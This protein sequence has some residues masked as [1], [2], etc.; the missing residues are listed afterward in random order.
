MA[1]IRDD[2]D[3]VILR[4]VQF[5]AERQTGIPEDQIAHKF[6]FESPAALYQRLSQDGF[7]VCRV[8][9][10]TPAESNHC[11]NETERRQRRARK[12]TGQ[13]I[14]LP[15]AKEAEDLF[16]RAIKSLEKGLLALD[17]RKEFYRDERFETVSDY[18]QASGTYAR[19]MYPTGEDWD[20][21]WEKVCKEHGQEPNVDSFF[22]QNAPITISEGATQSP[23][24]PLTELIALYVLA[25]MPLNPLLEALH[26][27][28]SSA[29]HERLR[30][31]VEQL[32]L[33]SGQLGTLVRGG[34]IRRGPSTGE[35]SHHEQ[36]AARFIQ[37]RLRQ[38]FS[39]AE[40]S[41]LLSEHG[42]TRQYITRLKNLRIEPPQ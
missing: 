24:E 30:Q 19:E 13:A 1:S 15:P 4:Y 10:H 39:E 6:N 7:P 25:G 2:H 33:K 8:C 35:L 12:G 18:P 42:Y 20:K 29:D 32:R 5:Y 23:P 3:P 38:G 21:E 37:R 17:S 14:E 34:R 36:N 31:A 41:K 27:D 11:K 16:R 9:G 28:P 40:I 22:V 26:P